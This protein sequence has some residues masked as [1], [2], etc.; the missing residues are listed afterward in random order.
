MAADASGSLRPAPPSSRFFALAVL[1][2][3][4]SGL[5]WVGRQA[6]LAITDS[7]VAP[8]ILGPDNDAVIASKL[9]LSQLEVERA[10]TAS[11]AE[12]IEAELTA[13]D[14]AIARLQALSRTVTGALDWTSAVTR[15]LA[16]A[17]ADDHK[18]LFAEETVLRE[19]IAQQERATESARKN[20][21]A[22]LIASADYVK[23]QLSLHQLR[24]ALLENGRTRAQSELALDQAELA[25][26]SLSSKRGA[27]AMPERIMREDQ[28]VRIE[29]DLIKLEAERRAKQ[30]EQKVVRDK[31]A[32]IDELEAQLKARPMYRA[33]AERLDLAFV[34]YTQSDGVRE[35]AEVYDCVWGLFACRAVG[36]VGEVVPG[37]TVLPDPWGNQSRGH[38]AILK[39]TDGAAARSKTLRVRPVH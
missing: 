3:F 32:K 17:S 38:F 27:P 2:A 15:R 33:V 9:S 7:F 21:A 23:E 18:T 22:G 31:L 39:L 28:L 13:A 26:S 36:T 20:L 6:Y 25:Q 8:I 1:A 29:L 10:K 16:A 24:V 30:S 34:P 37:E 11:E 19:M 35:G 12:S 5:F 14:R 4:S